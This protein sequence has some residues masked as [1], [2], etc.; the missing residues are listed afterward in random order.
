MNDRV[1]V[2]G[3]DTSKIKLAEE[4]AKEFVNELSDGDSLTVVLFD[5]GATFL[6]GP[7]S[8]SGRMDREGKAEVLALLDGIPA[9]GE[10]ALYDA[11]VMAYEFLEGRGSKSNRGI[12]VLSDGRHEKGEKQAEK[13]SAKSKML[14]KINNNGEKN[15]FMFTIG[16]GVADDPRARSTW[17]SSRRWQTGPRANTSRPIRSASAKSFARS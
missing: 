9:G 11:V 5:S 1:K 6:L 15:I 14:E 4:A 13:E 17:R 10:T 2:A 8:P 16:Y 3:K 7:D 12:V